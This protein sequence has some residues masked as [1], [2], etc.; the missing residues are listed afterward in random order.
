MTDQQL[1]ESAATMGITYRV[2]KDSRCMEVYEGDVLAYR[3]AIDGDLISAIRLG[4]GAVI[5]KRMVPLPTM[6]VGE[7]GPFQVVDNAAGEDCY[8]HMSKTWSAA[9]TCGVWLYTA[10]QMEDY[11]RC[12]VLAS[13]HNHNTNARPQNDTSEIP[14]SDF[15]SAYTNASINHA[16]P[17]ITDMPLRDWFAGQVLTAFSTDASPQRVA[18]L[19][20]QLADTML[21]T[22]ADHTK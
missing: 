12:A 9:A 11:A 13:R 14:A 15:T 22:R 16:S 4:L 7:V 3:C 21:A 6:P 19:A 17:S 1:M 10:A 8:D 20:Y 5:R 2:V 18:K